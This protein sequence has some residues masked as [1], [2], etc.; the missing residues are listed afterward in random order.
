MHEQRQRADALRNA[1]KIA[2]AAV[3]TLREH[4]PDVSLD[5][6]AR[7]A[8]IGSAT[9]YRRFGDRDGV[10]RAAFQTYFAEEIEPLV[11]AAHDAPDA[12]QAL[13]EALTATV[14]TLAAHRGLLKAAK[15]SGAFTVD[16]TARFMGP[17]GAV[18]TRAQQH[19]Q[20]RTDLIVRDLA[21]IVVMA[22]ATAHPD[23]P[24]H[25]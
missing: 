9:L 19:G 15:E 25:H 16:I 7:R 2:R 18:L 14:A 13:A 22:L 17:L 5:E 12:G 4:G 20:V 21:A 23:D 3:A 1:H 11:L 6:I 8:G 24:A 10:M